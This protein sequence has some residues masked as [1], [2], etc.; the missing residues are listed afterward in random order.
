MLIV[1]L[2]KQLGIIT[3]EDQQYDANPCVRRTVGTASSVVCNVTVWLFVEETMPP[4]SVASDASDVFGFDTA[5]VVPF[6]PGGA[7]V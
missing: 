3:T 4:Y 6:E 2:L 1:P 7:P 5:L